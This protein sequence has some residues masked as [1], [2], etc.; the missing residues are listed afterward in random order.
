MTLTVQCENM[1]HNK[2]KMEEYF[3]E[4]LKVDDV[5]AKTFWCFDY[6]KGSRASQSLIQ[7]K[8][9]KNSRYM[10]KIIFRDLGREFQVEIV[11]GLAKEFKLKCFYIRFSYN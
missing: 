4:F 11:R 8:N 9:P 7:D 3:L 10:I 1:L 5:E 2:I 6:A